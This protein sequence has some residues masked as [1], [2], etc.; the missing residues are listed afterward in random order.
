MADANTLLI[1]LLLGGLMG[2]LGQSVRVVAGLKKMND[3]SQRIHA[4]PVEL[5]SPIRLAVSLAI[6]FLAG[7][8]ATLVLGAHH[9]FSP[10]PE[11]LK[12]LLGIAATGYISADLLEAFGVNFFVSPRET[13]E[14]LEGTA[15]V[16]VPL[17]A[18]P[19]GGAAEPP[20]P[21]APPSP[22]SWQPAETKDFA[23]LVRGMNSILKV[24]T[25]EQKADAKRG[26]VVDF[27]YATNRQPSFDVSYYSGERSDRIAYG[28]ASVRIP[29][30]HRIGKVELPF[31]LRLFS[32]TFYEQSLDPE[33]HFV[34]E[35]VDVRGLDDWKALVSTSA[36]KQAL[37][38]VHGFNN[39]FRD[40]AYRTAQIM[41]DLQYSGLPVLFSWPS[42]GAVLDYVYDRDS[43][44]GAR[45]AFIETLRNLR[46]TGISRID[47]LAHSMGNLV[48]LDSLANHSHTGDPLGIT[49]ILMAAPDVDRDHYKSLA[50]KVR[51]VASGMTLYASSADRALAASKRLAGNIARA[52]D[53]P[54]SGPILVDGIDTIDVTAIGAEMFGLGHGSFASTR[55][56]LNDVGLVISTGTRP[57]NRR[58]AEIRGMPAG[59]TISKWWQYSY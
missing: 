9:F 29:E 32:L 6:G 4:R 44:F 47:V 43:A 2:L 42:R 25:F 15:P 50:A 53:V 30:S 45:D 20:P 56:I 22:Y 5:F 57:P 18:P 35:S 23:D 34:I 40:A 17:P 14:V 12:E 58:L 48:V 54:T 21:L 51:A 39:T 46:S 3:E 59:E 7:I 28:A 1:V 36:Q 16:W 49:E 8:A 13:T 19:A 24:D 31:K 33:K 52:G 26:Q 27:L 11:T 41:W 37:V 10:A 38:F 55:S